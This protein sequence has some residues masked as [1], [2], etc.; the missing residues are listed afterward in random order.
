MSLRLKIVLTVS[1]I[2]NVFLIGI[3]L[4]VVITGARIAPP[5]AQRRP[6]PNIWLAADALPAPERDKFRQMLRD[7]AAAV[8]PELKTVRLTR[9]EAASLISQSNYDPAAVSAALQRAREGEMHARGE[10]DTAFAEYLTHLPV[11]QR[12]ALADALVHN[13]PASLRKAAGD[14]SAEP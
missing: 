13:S 4:G 14:K 2:V 8:Q 11:T 1:L 5:Q 3:A 6:V 10:I 12:A 7:R 9:K